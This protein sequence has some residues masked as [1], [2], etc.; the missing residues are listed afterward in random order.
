M[1]HCCLSAKYTSSQASPDRLFL[2]TFNE[3]ACVPDI[4]EWQ[5]NRVK[6]H[7]GLVSQPVV[8][9][10][11]FFTHPGQTYTQTAQTSSSRHC[12][13]RHLLSTCL[14][15]EVLIFQTLDKKGSKDIKG[16]YFAYFYGI[17]MTSV[18]GGYCGTDWC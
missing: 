8:M 2:T 12:L 5:S 13:K 3:C 14:V 7:A 17:F 11:L 15:S 16:V 1:I 18:A 9:R 4:S 10:P 6:V